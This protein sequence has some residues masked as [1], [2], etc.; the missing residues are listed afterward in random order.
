MSLEIIHI[1]NEWF[2]DESGR[3]VILRGVN[4][5]GDCK[6]P[7]PDGGTENPTD[8]ST[9]REVSFVGRPFPMDE[10]EVHFSRLKAWGFNVLRLLLTWEAVE[11]KGPYTFD[12]RF[13]EYYAGLCK[14]AGEYGMY[15]FV[16][17]HQDAWSRMSGGDGAPGWLFEKIGLDYRA[18]GRADGAIVMQYVYDYNDPSPRQDAYPAM[19]W[20]SNCVYPVNGIM[21]SL[22]FAGKLI[23]PDFLIKDEMSGR[24]VNVQDYMQ[25]HYLACQAKVAERIK[26]LSNVIGFDSLNEPSS[27]WIEIPMDYRHTKMRKNNPPRPGTAFSPIDALYV[28]HG[29]CLELPYNAFSLLRGG[30]VPVKTVAVNPDKIS[31]WIN[32]RCDPF[33]EAGA[34]ELLDDGTYRILRNDFFKK[35]NGKEIDFNRD[36]LLPFL[37]AV[38]DNFRRFNPDWLLFAEKEAAEGMMRPGF[39][40]NMPENSVNASHWYDGLTL[41]NKK[42]R[43]INIDIVSLQPAF[44]LKGIE[45][46]YLRELGRIKKSSQTINHGCPTLIGEFGIPFDMDNGKAYSEYAEGDRTERPWQTH[47][48]ALDL[49]YN[50]LDRLLISSAHWNYTATNSNDLRT[51]DRFNQEDLSIYSPDQRDKP[52]DINSGGRAMAGWVRPYARCV[53]GSIIRMKF[54]RKKGVFLLEFLADPKICRPTEIFVPDLQFPNGYDIIIYGADVDIIREEEEGLVTMSANEANKV[55]V[56]IKKK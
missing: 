23:T 21:W 29:H 1:E 9:H 30:V 37:H 15:V 51:G 53:Q 45:K 40:D 8:F 52:D 55:S 12:E 56:T 42:F 4:L 50:A 39:P 13:L 32:G 25:G 18:F 34:W 26:G 17:F 47:I 2:K 20:Q 49:M 16:D 46:K 3:T 43:K 11:H 36:C 22:F 44:G 14:M 48:T 5:G 28:S 6:V 27:G 54:D 7:Y 24:E 19:C 35:A 33:I 38:A 31:I 41:M 10:A